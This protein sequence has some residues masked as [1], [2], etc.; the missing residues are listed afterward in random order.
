MGCENRLNMT[1]MNMAQRLALS[2]VG[3]Q[4]IMLYGN[5]VVA[6]SSSCWKAWFNQVEYANSELLVST[7]GAA[8][9]F[10]I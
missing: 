6:D 5:G 4:F 7:I 3:I 9:W 2:H 8:R 10:T 1:A